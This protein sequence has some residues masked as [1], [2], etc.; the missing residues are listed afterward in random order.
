MISRQIPKINSTKYKALIIRTLPNFEN[1]K[2]RDYMRVASSFFS[3]DAM[4]YIVNLGV[5]HLLVDTPS[6][7]RLYDDGQLTSHHIFYNWTRH[8]Y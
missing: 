8:K 3:I 2:N 7:D 5:K 1:K 6:V 4:E